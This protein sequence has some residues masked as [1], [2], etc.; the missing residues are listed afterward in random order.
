[1]NGNSDSTVNNHS[2]LLMK[3]RNGQVFGSYFSRIRVFT[4]MQTG[5][6][7]KQNTLQY[8]DVNIEIHIAMSVATICMLYFT[9]TMKEA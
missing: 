8:T 2:F 5:F 4:S 1:M 6:I 7:C 9:I 3:M